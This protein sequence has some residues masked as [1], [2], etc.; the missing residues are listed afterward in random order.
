[1]RVAILDTNALPFVKSVRRF[2]DFP[3]LR[4]MIVLI[5]YIRYFQLLL[6]LHVDSVLFEICRLCTRGM[7]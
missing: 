4:T 1:M 6:G 7:Y 3:F 2:K 5:F